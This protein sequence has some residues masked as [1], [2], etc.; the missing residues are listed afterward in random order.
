[1]FFFARNVLVLREQIQFTSG[2]DVASGSG[3]LSC[4]WVCGRTF[5]CCGCDASFGRSRP[6]LPDP[7]ILG[8]G[9]GFAGRFSFDLWAWTGSS[10]AGV[11]DQGRINKL[12]RNNWVSASATTRISERPWSG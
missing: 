7:F 4:C 10:L 6:G 12:V 8:C 9:E 11:D 5:C 1:M 3:A 2:G